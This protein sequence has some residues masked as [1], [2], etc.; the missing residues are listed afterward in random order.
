MAVVERRGGRTDRAVGG[1]HMA[2]SNPVG[3]H[4]SGL[5]GGALLG[6]ARVNRFVAGGSHWKRLDSAHRA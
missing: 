4:R 6:R 3:G 2:Q 1:F 5:S